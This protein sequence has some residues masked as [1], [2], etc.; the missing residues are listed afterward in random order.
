[1]KLAG[2]PNIG[3]TL[4][5]ELNSIGIQSVE[6]LRE[7][8]SIEAIIRLNI[9]GCNTCYNKFYALEGAIQNIRWHQLSKEYRQQLKEK[10]DECIK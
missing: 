6:E 5:M 9:H 10:Y 7:V 4:E 3:K 8:G 1:M 2:V